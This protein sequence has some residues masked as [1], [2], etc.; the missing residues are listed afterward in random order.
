[1]LMASGGLHNLHLANAVAS[2]AKGISAL[3][4]SLWFASCDSHQH[5]QITI[6]IISSSIAKIAYLGYCDGDGNSSCIEFIATD[7]DSGEDENVRDHGES[8]GRVGFCESL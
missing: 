4:T 8:S 5:Y 6:T 1:M 3:R 7:D 2:Q